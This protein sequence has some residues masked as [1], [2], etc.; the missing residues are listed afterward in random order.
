MAFRWVMRLRKYDSTRLRSK[1]CD[2]MSAKFLLDR[3]VLFF[4]NYIAV[5]SLD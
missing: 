3:S 1:S 5:S 2:T 4:Y